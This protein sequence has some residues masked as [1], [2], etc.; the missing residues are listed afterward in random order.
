[1]SVGDIHRPFSE[2]L[3]RTMDLWKMLQLALASGI[4]GLDRLAFGQF[5]VS[6]PIVAAPVIGAL[7]G[8]FHTGV[9]IG[10]VLELFWLRGLP[11]GGHVPRDATLSAVLTTGL[12]LF[13]S[14]SMERLDPA[15]IAW[16]FLWVGVLLVPAGF[17]DQMIRKKNGFLIRMAGSSPALERGV[18][19][20][21][22]TGVLIFFLYYFL[23]TVAVLGLSGPL[24]DQGYAL[25]SPETRAG[26]RLF[27]FLLPLIGLGSLLMQKDLQRGRVLLLG[28]G[29]VSLLVVAV[30]PGTAWGVAV[31]F[32]LAP[33]MGFLQNRWKV[34]P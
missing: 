2:D 8:D 33:A 32:L 12:C 21:V 27:F 14:R 31:L 15:W 28:G 30:M 18:A 24:L 5:M 1:M 23:I 6:Q 19:T 34:V 11:V 16:A 17:V 9:F 29:A 10:V 3:G 13:P 20:A 26:L 25:L 22:F 7:L 4:L